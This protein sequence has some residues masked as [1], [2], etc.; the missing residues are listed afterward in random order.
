MSVGVYYGEVLAYDGEHWAGGYCWFAVQDTEKSYQALIIGQ[1]YYTSTL[2]SLPG[3][4]QDSQGMKYMLSRL[5]PEFQVTRY[6]E[7][8]RAGILSAIRRTFAYTTDN[9][10]SI[11]YFSGHGGLGGT[12][13][14][15]DGANISPGQLRMELDQVRGTKVIIVDACYSG[16]LIGKSE[17]SEG[18]VSDFTRAFIQAFSAAGKNLASS[19]Y[20]VI[21]SARGYEVSYEADISSYDN[22]TVGRV[23]IFSHFLE[24]GCGWDS[25]KQAPIPVFGADVNGDRQLT[26]W[27]VYDYVRRAVLAYAQ[28]LE[29]PA[30][31]NAQCYSANPHEALFAY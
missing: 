7:Q 28:E 4:L 22:T 19:E 12:I 6:T 27:E 31:Q 14:G 17:G 1:G 15:T 3:S 23:G 26:F 10:V 5:K 25:V 18:S 24:E 13:I 2:Q 30:D 11:F 21:T 16:A 20:M 9:D 8:T 29:L